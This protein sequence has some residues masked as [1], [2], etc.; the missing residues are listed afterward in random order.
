MLVDDQTEIFFDFLM[1]RAI[2]VIE[3]DLILALYYVYSIKQTAQHV[4]YIY[5]QQNY[6]WF[7]QK[8]MKWYDF[9]FIF[10]LY[11]SYFHT[12]NRK[13]KEK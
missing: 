8:I 3:N 7:C 10:F 2:D 12:E 1:N 6:N 9:T 13:K 5:I 4:Y 11:T